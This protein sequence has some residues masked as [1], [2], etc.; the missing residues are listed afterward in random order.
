VRAHETAAHVDG[1]RNRLEQERV[2]VLV[3]RKIKPGRHEAF[4]R[5]MHEFMQFALKFPGHEEIH[6]LRP[7]GST[8]HDYMVVD[9]FA[10]PAARDAFKGSPEYREWMDHLGALSEGEPSIEEMGGLAGWF[11]LPEHPG[12][13]PPPKLKMA[14]VTFLAVFPLALVFPSLFK[15]TLPSLHPLL[16]VALI[17]VCIVASLTW[18]VMPLLTRLFRGWLFPGHCHRS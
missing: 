11:T 18:V 5:A 7:G 17:N 4:E 15:A 16:A 9:K 12:A 8:S 14:V 10:T 2:T 1:P 6:V 3:R 13:K